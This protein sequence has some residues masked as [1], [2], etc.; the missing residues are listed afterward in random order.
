[1]FIK[2]I[3]GNVDQQRCNESERQQRYYITFVTLYTVRHPEA[4]FCYKFCVLR[5]FV[6]SFLFLSLV[7]IDTFGHR[8]SG[9]TKH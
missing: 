5:N 8:E 6:T 4:E 1:M 7:T 2:V 3:Y 9:T